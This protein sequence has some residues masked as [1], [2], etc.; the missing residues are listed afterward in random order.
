MAEISKALRAWRKRLDLTRP[1][2]AKLLKIS[3]RTYEAWE[4]GRSLRHA[5]LME[6][7][8]RELERQEKSK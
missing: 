8:L 7:A 4:D 5:H 1:Q 6:L 2:A 3:P